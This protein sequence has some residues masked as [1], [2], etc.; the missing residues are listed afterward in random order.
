MCRFGWEENFCFP[1]EVIVDEK[2]LILLFVNQI[3]N[4]DKDDAIGIYQLL[5]DLEE[6]SRG[7]ST[8]ISLI[9][10]RYKSFE[11]K[12]YLNYAEQ[13]VLTETQTV[14]KSAIWNHN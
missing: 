6:V 9:L 12:V 1:H 2:R 11:K 13:D 3:Q 14:K 10:L 7:I 8:R 4:I 5:E